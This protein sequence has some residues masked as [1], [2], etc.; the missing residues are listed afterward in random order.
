LLHQKG[1]LDLGSCD[2]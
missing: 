2:N 1:C